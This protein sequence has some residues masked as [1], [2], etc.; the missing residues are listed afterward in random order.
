[1]RF[2]V[3]GA[4]LVEAVR[5]TVRGQ[6]LIAGVIL[7]HQIDHITG[8]VGLEERLL[9][10]VGHQG[11]HDLRWGRQPDIGGQYLQLC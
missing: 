3:T 2:A 8:G 5:L 4:A 1:M 11:V 9:T 6:V 10:T 7:T